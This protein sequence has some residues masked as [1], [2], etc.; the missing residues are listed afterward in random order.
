MAA[1]VCVSEEPVSN[2]EWLR[3]LQQEEAEAPAYKAWLLYWMAL[4]DNFS[5]GNLRLDMK[6]AFV[7]GFEAAQ[8]REGDR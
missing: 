5:Q 8:S 4:D 7:A 2:P 3:K 1:Q 6:N